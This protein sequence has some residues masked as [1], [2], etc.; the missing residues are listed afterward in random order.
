MNV[1]PFHTLFWEDNGTEGKFVASGRIHPGIE[2]EE[3]ES[4]EVI[5]PP[6]PLLSVSPSPV[7]FFL[8]LLSAGTCAVVLALFL[9]ACRVGD[10]DLEG[11]A[12]FGGAVCG[13]CGRGIRSVGATDAEGG[14]S[15]E[16]AVRGR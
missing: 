8:I 2:Q 9:S 14:S 7:R 4:T 1:G 15:G 6:F 16:P 12:E 10:V 5:N 3:T 13:V 11:W